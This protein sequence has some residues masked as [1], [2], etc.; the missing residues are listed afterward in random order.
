[1][2]VAGIDIGNT[3]TEVV[4]A[5]VTPQAVTPLTARRARTTGS[6]GS[7]ESVAGAARLALSAEKALGRRAELLLLPPLHPVVTMSASL[8]SPPR[9]A[10]LLRRL[11]DPCASTP[12][13]SGFAVGGHL[14]LRELATLAATHEPL[15]VSVPAGT[16]F[17][18]AAA[19]IA[20]AQT[21]R[22]PIVGAVV[23][24]DD[25]V[26]IANRIP[27]AIPIV[28]ETDVGGL[29][30]GELIA[31]EV[32]AP[33][34]RVQVAGDPVALVAA[35]GLAPA[36]AALLADLA[37]SLADARC[38]ALARAHEARSAAASDARGWLEY[39]AAAGVVRVPL[40][41]GLA[42]HADAIRPGSV[43]RVHVPPGAPLHDAIDTPANTSATCSPWTSRPS[44]SV[45]SPDRGPSSSP[46]CRSPS[47]SPRPFPSLPLK[48]RSRRPRDDLCACCRPRPRQPP[49]E[50]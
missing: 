18:D 46:T 9:A 35:F 36:E 39:D 17:E 13:G 5:E 48:R 40:S 38:V 31:V 41:R 26:L 16:D 6:K 19:T 45:S 37:M 24:G 8:P 43:R 22:L 20:A 15:I 10:P 44:A 21:A 33:G 32:A 3:T 27:R 34:G 1:M 49:S 30:S 29:P 28:D 2:I 11:D 47:W 14:P 7:D 4:I 23:A 42:E 12:S 50:P 25:A